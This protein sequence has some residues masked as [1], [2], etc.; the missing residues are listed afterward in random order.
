[1]PQVY[2]KTAYVIKEKIMLLIIEIAAGVVLGG[3]IL[4]WF[5]PANKAKR[6]E[7]RLV[8]QFSRIVNREANKQNKMTPEERTAYLKSFEEKK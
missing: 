5:S 6:Q 7:R 1:M 2:T 8:R 3:L 4:R